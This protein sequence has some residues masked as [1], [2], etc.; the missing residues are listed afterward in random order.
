M[1]TNKKRNFGSAL[2]LLIFLT[3][4]GAN[5]KR[6][7]L[8]VD[9]SKT[10]SS[11]SNQ[12][13]T[14]DGDLSKGVEGRE[15]LWVGNTELWL[16]VAAD[17]GSRGVGLSGRQEL[18]AGTGMIFLYPSAHTRSFWMK[19]TWVP[20]DVAFLGNDMRISRIVSLDPPAPNCTDADMPRA[21]SISPARYVVEMS[22]GWFSAHGHE[23]GTLVRFS[24]ELEIIAKGVVE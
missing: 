11:E 12:Q 13:T 20:L 2:V 21:K 4:C 5:P 8:E 10:R 3:A 14:A 7:P 18:L 15:R 23:V 6:A 19:N 22:K 24:P 9:G 17:A 16:E 1:P